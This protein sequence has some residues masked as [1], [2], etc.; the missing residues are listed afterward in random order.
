MLVI[1]AAR[2]VFELD[3]GAID[4]V[5]PA[6]QFVVEIGL[7]FRGTVADRL[8]AQ[9]PHFVAQP[10][11]VVDRP[12]YPRAAAGAATPKP[13]GEDL[14]IVRTSTAANRQSAPAVKNAGR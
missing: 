13:E 6:A 12:R 3:P 8:D 1:G 5:L 11:V 9:R 14:R 10:G 2:S 4:D 7:A